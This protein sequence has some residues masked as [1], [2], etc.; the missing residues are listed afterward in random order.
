MSD[1]VIEAKDLTKHY[2]DFVAID[3]LNFAV[4]RGEIVGLLGPN[5]AGKSTTM[6]ILTCFTAPTE[7][8]A[9]VNGHD[10]F[11]QPIAVR[12][13]IG[14]LPENTPLYTEMM[15]YE[16]LEFAAD[17]RGLKGA[18]AKRQ[19]KRAVEQTSLGDVVGK[20]IRA[21]SKGYRQRVGLAQALVHEPPLLILD[22]PMSGL[23]PN[24][25]IEVRDVIKTVGK[26][27]TVILSTHNLPEVQVTC[28]RVLI[29][30]RGKIVADDTPKA[31]SDRAGRARFLV[32][33][34]DEGDKTKGA[35]QELEKV[36]GVDLVRSLE[37]LRGELS[38]EIIPRVDEDLRPAL[39]RAV[40]AGSYTLV[41]LQR[42]GQNLEE[43]FRQLT[44]G[45]AA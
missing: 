40:V 17:M 23:D 25:A 33:L 20:E 45:K 44:V 31:L 24:Q 27:R 19:I 26:E 43:I 4:K 12:E 36:G 38:F 37:S 9:R 18:D 32:T 6:K 2:G 39:F 3:K 5:G 1:L 29:I 41:G 11:E 35:F 42:E 28:D 21:L 22:E 16:Y 13:A 14:Y 30:A 8:T 10:V 34:L 15:V 7:G